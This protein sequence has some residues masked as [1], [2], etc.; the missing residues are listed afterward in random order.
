MLAEL[1]G[2][3]T[4]NE[5]KMRDIQLPRIPPK[6]LDRNKV[7]SIAKKYST[8]PTHFQHYYPDVSSFLN[9]DGTFKDNNERNEQTISTSIA[10]KENKKSK[11]KPAVTPGTARGT[12]L[13]RNKRINQ[14]V[15]DP[16]QPTLT[17]M[18]RFVQKNKHNTTE[19][20]ETPVSASNTNDIG[21]LD[22]NGEVLL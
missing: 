15:H 3:T 5:A 7:I 2:T 19:S 8:I 21:E 18:F 9:D 4:I 6:E 10:S 12:V 1:F 11:R 13:K 22:S 16:N 20:N 17:S 14:I